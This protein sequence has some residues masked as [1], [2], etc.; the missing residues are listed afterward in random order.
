MLSDNQIENFGELS[1]R[2]LKV[3][4]YEGFNF[5][6]IETNNIF[7]VS[8]ALANLVQQHYPNRKFLNLYVYKNSYRWLMDQIAELSQGIIFINDFEQ[9]IQNPDIAV[10]FNQRRDKLAALPI[11]LVCF[12]EIGALPKISKA[13]PDLWS[14][15]NLVLTFRYLAPMAEEK[16]LR[17]EH[18]KATFIDENTKK[19]KLELINQLNEKAGNLN[20][21]IYDY[22]LKKSLFHEIAGL[23]SDLQLF[24]RAIEIE[25]KTLDLASQFNNSDNAEFAWINYN[26]GNYFYQKADYTAAK[27]SFEEAINFAEKTNERLLLANCFDGLELSNRELGNYEKSLEF[28]I[29]AN[30]IYEKILPP[31]H[32]NLATSYDNL[33]LIYRDM[34]N[35]LKALEFQLKAIEI[36]EKVLEPNH[37]DRAQSYNNLSSVYLDMGD[38]PKALDLQLKAKEIQEKFQNNNHPHLAACYNNLAR[39]YQDMGNLTLALEYSLKDIAICEKALSNDHHDLATSYGVICSIYFNLKDFEKAKFYIDKAIKIF[40]KSLPNEHPNIQTALDWQ[41]LVGVE[42]AKKNPTPNRIIN[43]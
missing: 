4:S 19:E 36:R 15:R 39:I 28:A 12:S 41:K 33:S 40:K 20:D 6:Y 27:T 7:Q 31:D 35:H 25:E 34:R 2:F 11:S 37:P 3:L 13:I 9:L 42:L 14:F 18:I 24:D 23:Y 32:P 10:P 38:L 8:K 5:V 16:F 29:K 30:D 21:D 17:T 22:P 26:I 43:T 1:A